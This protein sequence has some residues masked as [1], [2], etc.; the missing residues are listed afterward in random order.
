MKSA[1]SNYRKELDKSFKEFEFRT[2]NELRNTAITDKNKLWKMLNEFNNHA[3]QDTDIPIDTLY[4]Y[5]KKL[6]KSNEDDLQDFVIPDANDEVE[7]EFLNE[8]ISES[9]ISC[10]VKSLKNSKA[11]G[12][13]MIVNE[14]IKSTIHLLMPLYIALFNKI[15][16]SGIVPSVWLVGIIIPIFK[17]KGDPHN[18]D[19]YRGITLVSAVG[20]VFAALLNYRLSKYAEHVNMIPKVQAGFRKGYST[21]DNIFCL[22]ILIQLYFSAGKKLFCTFVDFKKAFDTVW[23]RGL[24]EKLILNNVQGK[25][26][27]VIYNM[28][29]G[30]KSCVKSGNVFSGFFPSEIGVRQGLPFF[31]PYSLQIWKIFL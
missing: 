23:R 11:A 9:E 3:N 20:K 10:I 14:Y 18:L 13:D 21:L 6:N 4:E 27:K 30:I 26:L 1:S 17:K 24:W 8:S 28:Y 31:F 5:F 12:Y 29:D 2:E 7:N 25:F 22:H 16:D 19:S 15:L